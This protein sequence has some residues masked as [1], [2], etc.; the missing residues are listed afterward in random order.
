MPTTSWARGLGLLKGRVRAR[1]ATEAAI[2]V[3]PAGARTYRVTWSV[4]D[5]E[6]V[7]TCVV[8]PSLSWQADTQE[9]A[10]AGFATSSPRS[11]GT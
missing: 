2:N 1:M 11:S 5:E 9:D 7:A 4:E 6:Y 3:A 10:W 8:L